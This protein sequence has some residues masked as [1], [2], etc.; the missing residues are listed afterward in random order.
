MAAVACALRQLLTLNGQFCAM[1]E[2]LRT[3]MAAPHVSTSGVHLRI[4]LNDA[5]NGVFFAMTQLRV[6]FTLL[7]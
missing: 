4:Q 2:P 5:G 1:F 7:H 3:F 6:R